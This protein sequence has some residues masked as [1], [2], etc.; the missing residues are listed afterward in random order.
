MSTS[1]ICILI[2]VA[3]AV[4]PIL[5]RATRSRA[6]LHR[7]DGGILGPQEASGG[8]PVK[9]P[10]CGADTQSGW[11][12]MWN[13]MVGQKVRWQPNEPGYVRLIVPT[14]AAVVLAA[15]SGGR[16]RRRASRCPNCS[17]TLIPP[18]ARYDDG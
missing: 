7:P 11:I 8:A 9:C 18:S 13:P 15:A 14:G 3:V 5:I 4:I 1:K 6:P 2:F 17:A 16:D 12:A 10:F